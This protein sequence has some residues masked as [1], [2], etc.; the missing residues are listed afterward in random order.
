[1][2]TYPYFAPELAIDE[3][4]V[5]YDN[6]VDVWAVGVIVALLFTGNFPFMAKTEEGTYLKIR[7]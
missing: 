3:G 2:G 4:V 1:M 6:K 5:K 7:T